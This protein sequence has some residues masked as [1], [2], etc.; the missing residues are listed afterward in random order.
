MDRSPRRPET[1]ANRA[2]AKRR[3]EREEKVKAGLAQLDLWLRGCVRQGVASVPPHPDPFWEDIAARM[4]D[5]QAPG[6]ARELRS[7]AKIPHVKT[8]WP[9]R[10]LAR[11]GRLHL[12]VEGFSRL[13]ELPPGTQADIRT[14]IGWTYDRETLLQQPGQFDRWWV[15]GQQVETDAAATP[16]LRARRV[17]LWGESC[18]KH[19]FSLEFAYGE[20]PFEETWDLGAAI[21]GEL[22]FY[23]SAYPLRGVLK[24]DAQVLQTETLQQMPGFKSI[25]AALRGYSSALGQNLWLDRFPLTLAR[26]VPE[27]G[28][29]AI[30]D[31]NGDRLP[32]A[33]DF[34][35]GWP[36]MA[37]SGGEAIAIFG[38]W[39]GEFWLPLS[40]F[41]EGRLVVLG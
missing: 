18:G 8:R 29:K 4:V 11:L 37:I 9:E 30:A 40:A 38:E 35:G 36:L 12:L 28:G 13:E 33:P 22:V 26:C 14:Q 41:A 15:L 34:T 32:V 24:P 39:D 3:R 10:L 21:E 5:A 7:M 25:A 20:R 1:A 23:P 27:S 19:A 17:W 16:N 31:E 6:I 2:K